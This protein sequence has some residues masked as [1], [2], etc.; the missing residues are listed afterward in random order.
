MRVL[1]SALLVACLLS[2]PLAHVAAGA[3]VPLAARVDALLASYPDFIASI[4]G[5]DLVLKDGQRLVI[6]DGKR[7]THEEKLAAGDIKDM[8]EQVYPLGACFSHKPPALN[9]EPGRIRSEPFFRR[10]YGNSAAEVQ[11]HLVPID[12]LGQK[13]LVTRVRGVERSLA[14]ALDELSRLPARFR[15]Y[16]AP[17]AGTFAWRTI[18]GTAQLSMHSFGIAIDINTKH[19][20]YWRWAKGGKGTGAPIAYKNQIPI[21]IVR[22]FERHGFIW[23]GKWYHYDTMHFEYRPELIRI[24]E[25]AEKAGCE[26]A[27]R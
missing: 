3:T 13:V 17:S 6:D 20:D 15:P 19:A 11:R 21:E 25:L 23:G 7:R 16:L 9:F 24:G 4:D 18:A 8:L 10:L 26:P 27:G 22:V 5:N 2:T 1:A 14:A 12:W